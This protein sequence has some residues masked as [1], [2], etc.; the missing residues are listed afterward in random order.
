MR[1]SRFYQSALFLPVVLSLALVGFIWQLIYSPDQGLLNAVTGGNDSTGTATRTSTSGR[2]WSPPAGGTTGYIMLLY[3]AGL[4]GVDPRCGR[5]PPSTAPRDA[6]LLPGRLPGA[7]PD[8]HHRAGHH[9]H[10]VAARVRHR[11]GHQQGPQRPR[12]D[13]RAGHPATSSARPAGSAS[14]R[15]WPRSCWSISSVFIVIYLRIVAARRT[16]DEHRR[17]ATAAE[18]RPRPGRVAP[19]SR[20]R[21]RRVAAARA[22][23]SSMALL[24][25]LPVAWAVL[26]TLPHLRRTPRST[27]TSRSAA[28]RFDNYADAWEQADFGQHFL[29]T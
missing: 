26:S 1:G 10:R 6:D 14:A 9:R 12:A 27:A 25:L 24:W 4:K 8:Q 28:S 17:R 11:L 18:R 22:S 15:R 29:N 13:L 2:C 23:S 20:P 3:L 16:S 21:G 5:R 19:A 7:A